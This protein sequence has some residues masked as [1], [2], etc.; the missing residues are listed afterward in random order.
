MDFEGRV[1]NLAKV[2]LGMTRNEVADIMGEHD[3]GDL[4]RWSYRIGLDDERDAWKTIELVFEDGRV[5]EVARGLEACHVEIHVHVPGLL[6][7]EE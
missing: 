3:S 2:M 4:N 1:R 5:K 6:A 7:G